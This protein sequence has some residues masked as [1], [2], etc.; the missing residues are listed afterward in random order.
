MSAPIG[1]FMP[2]H[3]LSWHL[4]LYLKGTGNSLTSGCLEDT[5]KRTLASAISGCGYGRQAVQKVLKQQHPHINGLQDTLLQVNNAFDV[6]TGEFVQCLVVGRCHWTVVS[7]IGCLPSV[8]RVYDSMN[9]QLSSSAKKTVATLL[10]MGSSQITLEYMNVQQ[11]KG[12]SDCGL[13]AIANA[14]TLCH[15]ENPV[16]YEYHQEAMRSHLLACL[17]IKALLPFPARKTERTLSV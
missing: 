7:N 4:P 13:F 10:H 11:Q 14:T 1:V 3:G 6:H 2:E 15:G 12:A 9:M 5:W 16:M 8:V 17:Q